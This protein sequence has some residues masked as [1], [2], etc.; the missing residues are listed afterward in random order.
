MKEDLKEEVRILKILLRDL[1]EMIK[2]VEKK[3]NSVEEG[4]WKKIFAKFVV[5]HYN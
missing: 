3:V 2:A 5:A 4:E 1:G